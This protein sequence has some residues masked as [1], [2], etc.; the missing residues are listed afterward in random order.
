ML[1]ARRTPPPTEERETDVAEESGPTGAQALEQMAA[2]AATQARGRQ[3]V[4]AAGR[5]N[6]AFLAGFGLLFGALCLTV[7]LTVHRS[8]VGLV[9]AVVAFTVVLQVLMVW[10][11]RTKK[12]TGRG[13]GRRS[14]VALGTTGALYAIG[15]VLAAFRVVGPELWFWLPYAVATALPMLIAAL[16][17][18]RRR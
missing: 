13:W 7:G 2:V 10:R 12:A 1:T 14:S 3:A 17:D 11:D 9:V 5:R 8:P 18:L 15:V 16:P 6:A 4:V